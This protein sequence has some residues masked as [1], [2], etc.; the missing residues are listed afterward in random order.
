MKQKRY[1]HNMKPFENTTFNMGEFVP[2]GCH[3]VVRG[4]FWKHNVQS[5]MRVETLVHPVMHPVYITTRHYYV[6]NRVAWD[7]YPEFVTG[8]EDNDDTTEH[9]YIDFSGSPVT[10]G[11]LANH[12]GLP[13]GFNGNANAL[14]FRMRNLIYNEHIRDDQLQAKLDVSVGNGADSTTDVSMINDN[15]FKDPFTSARPDD[16][17]GT[18][19]TIPLGS[20]APVRTSASPAGNKQIESFGADNDIRLY[21]E[22]NTE[23]FADLA[24]ATGITISALALAIQTGRLQEL[25]NRTGNK[26][27]DFL[28][29][30]GIKDFDSRINNP[31]YLGGGTQIVQFSEVLA[32]A[33]GTNTNVGDMSGHGIAASRSNK[34]MRF[35]PE[36]GYVMTF[37]SVRPVPMYMQAVEK[38]WLAQTKEDYFQ[39]EFSN[40]GMQEV[41]NQEVYYAHSSRDATFGYEP[42]DQQYRH[43]PNR[44]S[45]EFADLDKDWHYARDF[46]SDQALN[47]AFVTCSP[48]NR[49][50]ADTSQDQIKATFQHKISKMS[51]V[52]KY[53]PQILAQI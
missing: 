53:A 23:F 41:T 22:A 43:I 46:S 27:S 19:V 47:S 18:D 26:Y 4:E 13:V 29:R 28:D 45:G 42:R 49:V 44:V 39:K 9:P 11:S 33:E 52:P 32:T 8:G 48:T 40:I 35:F 10:K 6:P 38:H 3:R 50:Y 36:D 5:F 1:K 31:E 30:Y 34:Y 15:W 17:L 14:P 2:V 12:L 7:D 24:E 21:N 25:I 51:P 20:S 16:Q 37:V